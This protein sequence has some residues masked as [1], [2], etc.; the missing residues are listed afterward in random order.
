MSKKFSHYTWISL[1]TMI[2]LFKNFQLCSP[3][4]CIKG[5][6]DGHK[7]KISSNKILIDHIKSYKSNISHYSRLYLSYDLS[8]Q[9]MYDDFVQKYGKVCSYDHYR[10]NTEYFIRST[11]T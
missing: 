6:A 3:K 7:E 4:S 1:K 8:A 5:Y 11:W 10:I 9:K 2:V